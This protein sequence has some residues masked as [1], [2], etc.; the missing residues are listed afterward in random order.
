MM[1]IVCESAIAPLRIHSLPSSTVLQAVGHQHNSLREA[2]VEISNSSRS[3][4]HSITALVVPSLLA[5][6]VPTL[7]ADG[8]IR[9]SPVHILL[10][11]ELLPLISRATYISTCPPGQAPLL[12]LNTVFGATWLGQFQPPH[13]APPSKPEEKSPPVTSCDLAAAIAEVTN[14]EL[15]ARLTRFWQLENLGLHPQARDEEH[16]RDTH[17]WEV[18]KSKTKYNATERRYEIPLIFNASHVPIRNNGKLAEKCWESQERKLARDGTADRYH[19]AMAEYFDKGYAFKVPK[20]LVNDPNAFYLPHHGVQKKS[21][22]DRPTRIVWNGS[23]GRLSLNSQ[24]SEGPNLIRDL[25]GCAI[26]LRMHPIAI[27]ADVKGMFLQFKILPEYFKYQRF[28]Y[29]KNPKD[30]IQDF[31]LSRCTFGLRDSPS[32]S[33]SITRLHAQKYLNDPDLCEAAK[34]IERNIFM[35]DFLSGADSVEEGFKLYQ[36]VLKIMADAGLPMVKWTTNSKELKARFDPSITATSKSKNISPQ[37]FLAAAGNLLEEPLQQT[38]ALGLQ[39]CLDTDELHFEG[40]DK[41]C[42]LKPVSVT[43]RKIAQVVPAIFDPKGILSPFIL[44]A[45]QILQSCWQRQIDWD[46]NCPH[47]IL[48]QWCKWLAELPKLSAIRI[49]RCIIRKKPENVTLH[50]FGDASG[51]ALGVAI[52]LHVQ[53]PDGSYDSNLIVAKSKSYLN[54]QT[55]PRQELNAA[56]LAVR[57]LTFCAQQLNVPP[58]NRLAYTDSKVCLFWLAK[59]VETWKNYVANRCSEIHSSL[60]LRNWS[61]VPGDDNPADLASRGGTVQDLNS[62]LWLKGPIN[63]QQTDPRPQPLEDPDDIFFRDL[64]DEALREKKKVSRVASSLSAISTN[65]EEPWANLLKRTPLEKLESLLRILAYVRR[66]A[67]STKFASLSQKRNLGPDDFRIAAKS[68]VPISKRERAKALMFLIG[69][70]QAESFPSDYKALSQGLQIEDGSKLRPLSPFYDRKNQLIRAQSRLHDSPLLSW[71]EKNPVILPPPK[72]RSSEEIG[73]DI[74]GRI[75]WLA[76]RRNLHSSPNWTHSHLRSQFWVVKGLRS[77]KMVV[78]RCLLC[79]RR[80]AP[81]GTQLM[82]NLPPL[83]S[84]ELM[85]CWSSCGFDAIGPFLVSPPITKAERLM[86]Q[87]ALAEEA[88]KTPSLSAARQ[89]LKKEES[90]KVWIILFTCLASRAVHFEVVRN[91]ECDTFLLA[92][93]RFCAQNGYVNLLFCDQA[94]AFIK[95]G[96][97]LGDLKFDGSDQDPRASLQSQMNCVFK[98]S[99]PISPWQGGIYESLVKSCKEVLIK[100]LGSHI[101]SED[102]FTTVVKEAQAI[103]SDRPLVACT[104]DVDDFSVITPSQLDKGRKLRLFPQM[105]ENPHLPRDVRARWKK[106]DAL[107]RHFWDL[108][109]RQ[110]LASLLPRRKWTKE[111]SPLKE[112]DLV[113]VADNNTERGTWP[114]ARV[115]AVH[116][117]ARPTRS[118]ESGIVRSVTVVTSKRQELHRAV[119]GLVPL[120]IS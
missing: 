19:A 115:K 87:R 58:Y 104:Q 83:R 66:V 54:K 94:K 44:V 64:P 36:D 88:E 26:R 62:R 56:V 9:Q 2:T 31:Y 47:D 71:N 90:Y 13:Q 61:H 65:K 72:C 8:H 39:W 97:E 108:W 110:Y 42:P 50:A 46:E 12:E 52:Y 35:D 105:Q 82:A 73:L 38:K 89:K 114:L 106:R 107:R 116:A 69:R 16:K 29:R 22:P 98:F 34:S 24:L 80:T 78:N 37:G 103:V 51:V 86:R 84:G 48:T 81:K 45:K 93:R 11:A 41:I 76:H 40:Y 120:E 55:I 49:P 59:P 75:I 60:A 53:Y 17:F 10:G 101:V 67:S 6:G 57:T 3:F 4:L 77:I 100:T 68:A 118:G 95:A 18:L 91:L 33:C 7:H 119:Q 30:P 63:L 85:E 113:L 21:D 111:T 79:K 28:K 25:L 23:F 109:R 112:G 15:D 96:K 70:Y 1:Q 20:H 27:T 99:S 5:S 92:F 43:K 32:K 102:V 14:H 117:S 74:S